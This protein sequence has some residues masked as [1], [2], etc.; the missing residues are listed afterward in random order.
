MCAVVP[1]QSTCLPD[2]V[3]DDSR[4]VSISIW[5]GQEAWE[6]IHL[7]SPNLEHRELAAASRLSPP[8][9]DVYTYIYTSRASDPGRVI[10]FH[11]TSIA[12]LYA[13]LSCCCPLI[14]LPH[15]VC[16][17]IS[18][19]GIRSLAASF[20]FSSSSDINT[21]SD[22]FFIHAASCANAT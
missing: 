14:R 20:I 1:M 8:E 4:A 13:S 22:P 11:R 6:G 21:S 3:I 17:G 7:R 15:R 19:F 10:G 18:S 2:N 9:T 5:L 12:L 16:Y